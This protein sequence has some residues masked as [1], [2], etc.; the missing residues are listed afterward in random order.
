MHYKIM[1]YIHMNSRAESP[2]LLKN[3]WILF[4]K[5]SLLCSCI[6]LFSKI[7]EVSFIWSNGV[8]DTSSGITKL[9]HILA[10]ASLIKTGQKEKHAT[11]YDLLAVMQVPG[12][13]NRNQDLITLGHYRHINS[14][15]HR[16]LLTE[17]RT[18]LPL[19]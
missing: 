13:S 10:N 3:L 2:F 19:V 7:S 12:N 9:T 5:I 15:C 17:V 1:K 18:I 16:N 6:R 4:P 8:S 11:I 14:D